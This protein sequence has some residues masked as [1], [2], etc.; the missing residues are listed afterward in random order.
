ME[1]AQH[2]VQGSVPVA[3]APQMQIRDA[4]LVSHK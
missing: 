2:N 1:P 3:P 4:A